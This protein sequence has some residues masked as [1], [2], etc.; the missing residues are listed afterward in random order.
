MLVSVDVVRVSQS[1]PRLFPDLTLEAAVISAIEATISAW[2]FAL[3]R[4]MNVFV[5]RPDNVSVSEAVGIKTDCA[6][7]FA[8]LRATSSVPPDMRIDRAATV[9]VEVAR[10]RSWASAFFGLLV[11]LYRELGWKPP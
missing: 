8:V 4:R 6:A 1:V 7:A 3:R 9:A 10:E 5:L 2:R 11:L